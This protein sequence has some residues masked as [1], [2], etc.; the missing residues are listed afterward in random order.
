MIHSYNQQTNKQNH[1]R[2]KKCARPTSTKKNL[3]DKL[4]KNTLFFLYEEPSWTT[5]L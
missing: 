5:P 1:C 2:R 4:L 3:K